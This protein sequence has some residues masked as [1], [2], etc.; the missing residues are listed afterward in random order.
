M[1][2]A[3]VFAFE[4]TVAALGREACLHCQASE[5]VLGFGYRFS[6]DFEFAILVFASM[7]ADYSYE[8]GPSGVSS[9]EGEGWR[10]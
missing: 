10:S 3:A 9:R 6:D 7:L 1:G 8:V 4:E 5:D 2:D